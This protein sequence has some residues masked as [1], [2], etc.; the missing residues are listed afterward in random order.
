MRVAIAGGGLGGLA[1][2]LFLL[3][4]G[5]RDVRVFEQQS[6]LK[7][8]GA[9]IQVAPNAVRLL[10]RVG[11]GSSLA[12]VAVPFD[13]AWEFRRWQDGRVLF[14]Q[15][16]GA[17]GEARFGAPYLAVHRADLLDVLAAAV[18]DGV[19]SLGQHVEAID[20]DRFVFADGSVSQPFDVLIGADGIH[21]VVRSAIVGPGEP[22]FTGLAAYRALVPVEEAPEFARRPVCSIWLGPSRHF[23]HYPVSGGSQVNLVT[24]NPAGDWREE[25]WTAE[26]SV[27]DFLEEFAGWDAAVLQLI[28]AARETRRY[29]FYAREPIPRWV[30]GRVALLGD[31]AH[32][33]LPFFAQGAGQAI[34]DGA[35]LAGCLRGMGSSGVVD[36]LK[37]YES[38]RIERATRVQRASGERREHHHMPDGPE[39]LERDAALRSQDPLGH[40]EW[41]YGHDVEADL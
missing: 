9:G 17:E 7:E 31:A 5:V 33:M 22:V 6:S 1:A 37:R 15:S 3:R 12:D 11:V 26:G 39:Q 16:F 10:Q 35:V 24:A 20:G 19:V 30:S 27:Q 32:P 36:A 18:P 13:V 40:N 41:L 4:A 29:A 25:S 14:S 28:G 2:A 8:I 23:V 34:E 21:S 38:L